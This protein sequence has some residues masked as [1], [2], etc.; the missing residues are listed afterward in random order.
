[1]EWIKDIPTVGTIIIG[2]GALSGAIA[3]I[4]ALAKKISIWLRKPSPEALSAVEKH[5]ENQKQISK[6]FNILEKDNVRFKIVFESIW[7]ILETNIAI[8]D[9]RTLKELK[10]K[11]QQYFI[12]NNM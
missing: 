8:S 10:E 9:D 7:T 4:A 5:E 12:Q 1:M 2:L 6:L 3:G 11:L